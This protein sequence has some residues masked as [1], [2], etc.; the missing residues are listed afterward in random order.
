MINK[1]DVTEEMVEAGR[2]IANNL[3]SANC[4]KS[5]SGLGGVKDFDLMDYPEEHRDVITQYLNGDIDSVTAIY[6]A[7]QNASVMED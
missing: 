2:K 3:I 7:M 6:I 5:M 1:C 4:Q